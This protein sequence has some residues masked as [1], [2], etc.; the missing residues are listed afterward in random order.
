MRRNLSL[1]DRWGLMADRPAQRRHLH[2]R[3]PRLEPF[4]P[5]LQSSAIDRL[6]QVLTS[7][8]TE[9]MRHASLLCRLPNPARHFV[10]DHVIVRSISPQQ[11]TET[12]HRVVLLRLRQLPRRQRDLKRPW[13]AYQFYIFFVR[14]RA[15]QSINRAQQQPLSDKRIEA[16]NDNREA[17]ARSA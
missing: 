13:H 6:F 16:G 14:A 5:H 11:T 8:H 17:P 1:A 10:Y 9:R 4:I 7:K 12:N 3:Q 2:R 15:R